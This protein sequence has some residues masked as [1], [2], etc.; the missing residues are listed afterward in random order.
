MSR[1]NIC[2]GNKGSEE[3]VGLHDQFLMMN[4]LLTYEFRYYV[5]M[6]SAKYYSCMHAFISHAY[7]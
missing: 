2:I 1:Q 3:R 5:Y 7:H 6:H 4:L